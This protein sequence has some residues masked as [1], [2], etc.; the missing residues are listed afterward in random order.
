MWYSFSFDEDTAESAEGKMILTREPTF[1]KITLPPNLSLRISE[2][3]KSLKK[4]GKKKP[5]VNVDALRKLKADKVSKQLERRKARIALAKRV[6]LE[7]QETL[8][9]QLQSKQ[10]ECARRRSNQ[11]GKKAAFAKKSLQKVQESKSKGTKDISLA[12]KLA[13]KQKECAMRR[14]K[15]HERKSAFA[16]EDLQKVNDAPATQAKKSA[17]SQNE[18]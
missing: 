18:I 12:A 7:N 14:K 9:K 16:R 17:T 11:I 15:F 8:A 4:K 2:L 3:A 1:A 13:A 5:A 6:E 10:N